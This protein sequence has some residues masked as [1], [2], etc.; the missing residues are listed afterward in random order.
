MGPGGTPAWGERA[1]REEIGNRGTG[2]VQEHVS[3]VPP[4]PKGEEV[5]V[6][7]G[8][9]QGRCRREQRGRS[10]AERDRDHRKEPARPG[11]DPGRAGQ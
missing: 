10:D 9:A 2:E 8:R 5:G 7:V 6:R 4:P 3:H 1:N 11:A